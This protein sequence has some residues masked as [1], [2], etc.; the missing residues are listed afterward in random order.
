M[1]LIINADDFGISENVNNTILMMHK[2][3]IVKSTSIVAAGESFIHAVEIARNNP[4]LGIGVHLCLDGPFNIG[5][6]YHS[7]LTDSS[8]EFYNIYE[9]KKKLKD[10]SL[11]ESEIYKEYCLQIEKVIDHHIQVSHLDTHHHLHL[12]LPFLNCLIKAA[13]KFKIPYIR[14]QKVLLNENQSFINY[15]YRICHQFYLK[16]RIK[17][18]DGFYEHHINEDSN[19]EKNYNRILKLLTTENSIIEIILHP[20]DN[21][22]PETRFF[23]SKRLLDLFGKQNLINYHDLN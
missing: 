1:K 8:K 10:Y 14:T 18:V 5:K 7:I 21:D 4:N 20:H 13:K 16:S 15:F 9:V 12:Y 11:Y 6:D 22:D 23:S 17:A 19:Y 3:G 2:R